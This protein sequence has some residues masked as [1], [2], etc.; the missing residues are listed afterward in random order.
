MLQCICEEKR[1]GIFTA[2]SVSD[3]HTFIN[4]PENTDLKA[5]LRDSKLSIS[6][7]QFRGLVGTRADIVD[8]MDTL[9]IK[10]TPGLKSGN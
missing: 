3:F 4:A 1:F 7:E 10:P 9:L 6:D 5:A 2:T 8:A